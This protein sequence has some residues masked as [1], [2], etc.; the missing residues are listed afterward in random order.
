MKIRRKTKILTLYTFALTALLTLFGYVNKNYILDSIS[1]SISLKRLEISRY[2]IELGGNEDCFDLEKIDSIPIS[3]TILI[4][5]AYGAPFKAKGRFEKGEDFLAPKV[6]KFLDSANYKNIEKV[7]FTGDLFF[8][9][10]EYKWQRL[11]KMFSNKFE[12]VIAPGNHDVGDV[13]GNIYRKI[14]DK[15]VMNTK[16]YPYTFNSSGFQVIVVDNT[17]QSALSNKNL[18]KLIDNETEQPIIL[19]THHVPILDLLSIGNDK[20]LDNRLDVIS[21]NQLLNNFKNKKLTIISGDAGAFIDRPR[22]FCSKVGNISIIING[23]GEIGKDHVIV[24]SQGK[25]YIKDI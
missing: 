2:F 24:L 20:L 19:A 5:H 15:N 10:N 16:L 17:V 22:I 7:I 11:F 23:I 12:I 25:I 13:S 18:F 9:P 21:G 6:I 4:G 14:F 1:K 8:K 3:S